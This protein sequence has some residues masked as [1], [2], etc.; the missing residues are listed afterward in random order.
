MCRLATNVASTTLSFDVNKRLPMMSP[1][2]LKPKLLG[3]KEYTFRTSGG[4]GPDFFRGALGLHAVL[5]TFATTAYC[6]AVR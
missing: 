4:G 1:K 2:G 6:F 5:D 3:G